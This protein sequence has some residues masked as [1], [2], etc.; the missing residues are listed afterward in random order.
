[1][2]KCEIQGKA[3]IEP[4][5]SKPKSLQE[6]KSILIS[7]RRPKVS[8]ETMQTKVDTW[9]HNVENLIYKLNELKIE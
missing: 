6:L 9:M 8:L 5:G 2:L 3:L 1:M 4:G 7:K